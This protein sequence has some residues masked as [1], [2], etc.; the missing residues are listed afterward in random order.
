MSEGSYEKGTVMTEL[1][2]VITSWNDLNPIQM[3]FTIENGPHPGDFGAVNKFTSLF[4][5][6]FDVQVSPQNMQ[7]ILTKTCR[8]KKKIQKKSNGAYSKKKEFVKRRSHHF[9]T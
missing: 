8:K 7:A 5:G 3:E 2:A 6:K 9:V 1:P 4:V